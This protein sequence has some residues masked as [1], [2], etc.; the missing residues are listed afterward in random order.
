M[1]LKKK[2]ERTKKKRIKMQKHFLAKLEVSPK[3]N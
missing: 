2:K 1:L 3:L